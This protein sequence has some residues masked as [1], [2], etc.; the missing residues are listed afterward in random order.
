M[1]IAV[2]PRSA[3]PPFEQIRVQVI[4]LVTA[5]DLVPETRLPT[6]RKL[7]SDLGV[8]PNTVARAYRELEA[9]GIIETRGRNGTFVSA[10]GDP[11]RQQAQRVAAECADRMRQLGIPVADALAL[12]EAALQPR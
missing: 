3:V 9:D 5:G 12:V 2:D 10:H 6:V 8:A 7:A 1:L 11:A 4:A